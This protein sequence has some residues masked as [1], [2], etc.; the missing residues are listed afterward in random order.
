MTYAVLQT[1]ANPFYAATST[2]W[3]V[4]QYVDSRCFVVQRF[5]T[6]SLALAALTQLTKKQ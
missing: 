5:K 1:T 6:K 4:V 3:S 2:A